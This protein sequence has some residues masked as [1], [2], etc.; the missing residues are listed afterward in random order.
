MLFSTPQ[1]SSLQLQSINSTTPLRESKNQVSEVSST[2][3]RRGGDK[4]VWDIQS[5]LIYR[6]DNTPQ[7][8]AAKFKICAACERKQNTHIMKVITLQQLLLLI[9]TAIMA[10]VISCTTAFLPAATPRVGVL[11]TPYTSLTVLLQ[12]KERSSV[13]QQREGGGRGDNYYTPRS[14]LVFNR[15]SF[16]SSDFSWEGR[17]TLLQNS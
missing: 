3:A 16:S 4:D 9:S 11:S 15:I 7:S 12:E 17:G 1:I 5:H 14:I 6:S 13:Y 8:F 10:M 2:K